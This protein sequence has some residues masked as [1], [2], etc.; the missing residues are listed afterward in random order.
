MRPRLAFLELHPLLARHVAYALRS[1]RLFLRSE[2]LP[3]PGGFVELERS[4]KNMASGGQDRPNER[5]E[6]EPVDTAPMRT[7]L[8]LKHDEA[9]HLLGVS[10]RTVRRL[11]A[12]GQLP[13]VPVGGAARVHRADVEAF[14]DSRR[15]L[16]KG[17]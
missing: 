8:L 12:E 3:L 7:P 15:A 17:A 11:V 6:D 14:A 4:V 1:H 2:H 5:A 9:G 16:P 13:A 10:E